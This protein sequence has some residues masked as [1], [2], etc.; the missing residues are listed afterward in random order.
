[1]KFCRSNIE[2]LNKIDLPLRSS[3]PHVREEKREEFLHYKRF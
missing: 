1:M 3:Y 2:E